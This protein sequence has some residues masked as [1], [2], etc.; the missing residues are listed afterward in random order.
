MLFEVTVSM[1]RRVFLCENCSEILVMFFLAAGKYRLVQ[2]ASRTAHIEYIEMK[3]QIYM[4][5]EANGEHVED[6]M[7]HDH[8]HIR[9]RELIIFS[10]RTYLHFVFRLELHKPTRWD[11][12]GIAAGKK[13]FSMLCSL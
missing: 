13:Y 5:E 3:I 9:L 12:K 1:K 8:L 11:L 10:L 2:R 4:S 6:M 7:A